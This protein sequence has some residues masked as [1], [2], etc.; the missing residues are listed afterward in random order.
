MN[1][2]LHEALLRFCL[3][4]LYFDLALARSTGRN[5]KDIAQISTDITKMETDLHRLRLN[6]QPSKFEMKRQQLIDEGD[7]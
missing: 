4:W 6:Y 1:A 3:W 2:L 5:S 7:V